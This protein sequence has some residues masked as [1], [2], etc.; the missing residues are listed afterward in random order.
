M[1]KNGL[2]RL[3][4]ELSQRAGI[5]EIVFNAP[6]KIFVE[7]DGRFFQLNAK[8]TLAE[9]HEF[10]GDVA[11]HNHRPCDPFHPV[12]DGLLPDGSRINVILDPVAFAAP[13]ITIRKY[14]KK[15][16]Q[17]ETSPGIFGLNDKYV[18]FLKAL[19]RAKMNII[20]SGSTGVGKTTCLNLLLQEVSVDSRVIVIEDTMELQV[21]LPNVVRLEA[22]GQSGE[23]GKAMSVRDLVKNTLRMRPDRLVIG[24]IRGEEVFDLLQMMNTGHAGSMTSIHS[25][26]PTECL[27]RLET[28]YHLAGHPV[29]APAIRSQISR[30]VNFII[31]VS[32]H[33]NGQR[34]ISH[35]CELGRMEGERILL[36][37]IASPGENGS[38]K[39]QGV[40]PLH[41]EEL[42]RAGL[43][44]DFF[45]SGF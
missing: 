43:P 8:V 4:E 6:E 33:K 14:V 26:S 21:S 17:F 27:S 37:H 15:T 10:I 12:L 36:N 1:V 45:N 39:Y 24:E 3:I 25:N 7:K 28:L 23:Q 42:I 2:W 20:V 9:M 29:A 16:V 40:T 11:K 34:I 41:M 30:A 44:Q 18:Q 13:A 19:V 31:Q 5:T 38:L 35:I 32:R 22:M